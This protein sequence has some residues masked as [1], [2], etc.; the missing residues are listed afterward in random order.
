MQLEQLLDRTVLQVLANPEKDQFRFVTDQGNLDYYCY[1]DCCSESWVNH[2]SDIDALIGQKVLDV[3]EIDMYKLLGAEPEPT[4]QEVDEVLFHRI[5]TPKG[6]CV[7]EFRN[8]SNG[9]Y[10]GSFEEEDDQL[11]DSVLTPIT[12][13]F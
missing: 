7:I 6:V 8:S 10:G 11:D 2:I 5:Q 1:G 12:E 3:E 9:Y 4:R 13:D